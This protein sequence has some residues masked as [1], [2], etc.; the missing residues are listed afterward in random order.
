MTMYN[1]ECLHEVVE[2]TQPGEFFRDIHQTIA[3]VIWDQYGAGLPCDPLSI[4][5]ALVRKG[6]LVEIG[7][8][9]YLSELVEMV[10]SSANAAYYAH[11][12]HDKFV[13]RRIIEVA[14]SATHRAYSNTSTSDELLES[15]ES[16]IFAIADSRAES[17]IGLIGPAVA[18]ALQRLESRREGVAG[19][20]SGIIGLDDLTDGWQ[21]G[22]VIIIGAR[23]SMGKTAFACNIIEHAAMVAQE[24]VLFVSL[25]MTK[26]EI[27]ERFISG[28][29]RIGSHRLKQVNRLGERDMAAIG[30]AFAEFRELPV[31]IDDTPTRT[32]LKIAAAARRIKARQGLG[33]IVVDYLQLVDTEDNRDTRE[34]KVAKISRRLKVLGREL[35]VPVIVLSQLNRNVENRE[36]RRP[37][38]S[39][40][41]ESGAIEQ[42]AD[43]VILLH[44]PEY[45]DPN[46]QPGVAEVILAKN[47]NGATS[48]I[49]TTFLK[50]IG[51]FENLAERVEDVPG[52][53]Y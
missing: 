43:V 22:Q 16:E 45:Y 39:D 6:Q 28:R 48:T 32:A 8:D 44:R 13:N 47:R 33:L 24:T 23:P 11:I 20:P 9:V 18:G 30:Q 1:P 53:A 37:R 5:E 3:G 27:A 36:D 14:N 40:L 26:T 19:V 25:E 51:R 7:G 17:N 42:D 34:E 29:T 38:M 50:D 2:I 15:I 21:A 35:K 52:A 46:D 4:S 31:W 49:K 41:R 10:V 12:V